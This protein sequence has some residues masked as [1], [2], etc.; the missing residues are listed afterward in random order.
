VPQVTFEIYWDWCASEL[1]RGEP[2]PAACVNI[3]AISV[4]EYCLYRYVNGWDDALSEYFIVDEQRR[5][6][7]QAVSCATRLVLG[8]EEP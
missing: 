5:D 7:V 3:G 1:H 6:L 8:L 4:C 2:R